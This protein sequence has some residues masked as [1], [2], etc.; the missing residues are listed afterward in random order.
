[1]H[2]WADD[3][4]PSGDPWLYSLHDVIQLSYLNS[5]RN[6]GG[7]SASNQDRKRRDI[8]ADTGELWQNIGPFHLKNISPQQDIS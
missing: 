8:K 6:R 1:M 4:G 7:S 3:D 2:I 5:R